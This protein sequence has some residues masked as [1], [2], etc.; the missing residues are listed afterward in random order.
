MSANDVA[1]PVRERAAALPWSRWGAQLRAVVRLEL[2][3]NFFSRRGLWVYLLAFA[4]T[5]IIALHAMTAHMS[6]HRCTVQEDTEILAGIFQLFYLRLGVFFGCVG[7][8]TRLFRG[9]MIEKSL[10][11]YFLA[12]IRRELLTLGKYLAGA[13]VAVVTFAT[14]LFFSFLFMYGHH[15]EAG[16]E[17]VERGP[18]SGHLAAY[19]GVTALA[20]VG[21]GAVFLLMGVLYRNPIIPAVL[22]LGW[23]TINGILPAAAKKV[24]VIF[25][26]KPLCPVDVPSQG[27]LAL[28]TVVSEP[29]PAWLAV[30]GLL[31]VAAVLL[32]YA[33][34]RV[35]TLEIQYS[36]E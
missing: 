28:F 26:L 21:Y 31:A 16:R 22:V 23:E 32:W 5:T 30:S 24:S 6:R 19:L 17:F 13:V 8:F 18:G 25:Y 10:H 14:S 29:V 2:R 9:E 7:I 34:R 33:C 4:P 15:G 20:C 11:F 27:L 1:M 36:S 12:P 3:K 35:R